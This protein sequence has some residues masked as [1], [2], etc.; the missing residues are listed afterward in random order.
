MVHHLVAVWGSAESDVWAVG[1]GGTIIHWDDSRWAPFPSGTSNNFSAVWGS[2]ANDV[3]AL[4]Y[5]GKISH[6]DGRVW[7]SA[8]RSAELSGSHEVN[9][10]PS[11]RQTAPPS[12]ARR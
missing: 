1:F 3:W 9:P 6:W 4:S 11:K 10:M 12:K 7:S 5:A 2:Q 8:L